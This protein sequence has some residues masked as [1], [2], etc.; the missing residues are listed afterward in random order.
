MFDIQWVLFLISSIVGISAWYE[1]DETGIVSMGIRTVKCLCAIICLLVVLIKLFNKIYNLKS[2]IAFV[3]F[4]IVVALSAY[5]SKNVAN[6]WYFVVFAAAYKQDAKRII[7]LSVLV[8]ALM[9]FVIIVQ[10]SRESLQTI[11]T[12]QF[13]LIGGVAYWALM[14]R[15]F[16]PAFVIAGAF[17]YGGIVLPFFM[18]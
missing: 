15:K 7:S 1:L 18:S 14:I 8:T 9:M 6:V 5:Y 11:G 3:L 12:L 10:M 4:G 17:L 13:L 16:H 2:G